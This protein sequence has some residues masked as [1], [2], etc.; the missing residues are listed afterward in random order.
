MGLSCPTRVHRL[1]GILRR[2]CVTIFIVAYGNFRFQLSGFS[3]IFDDLDWALV[4][5]TQDV[6]RK[7]VGFYYKFLN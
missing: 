6:Q 1:T 2:A 7:H 4:I 3:M 5:F